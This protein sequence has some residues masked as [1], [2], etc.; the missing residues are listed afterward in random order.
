MAQTFT[1]RPG[2]PECVIK[3]NISI[4][5]GEKIYHLPGMK[6][7]GRTSIREEYGERWFCTEQEAIEAGGGERGG[8]E[9]GILEPGRKPLSCIG[10]EA[11]LVGCSDTLSC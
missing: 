5:T 2:P 7:Y 9:P 6:D 4:D 3:G 10:C 8:R 11:L 1:K